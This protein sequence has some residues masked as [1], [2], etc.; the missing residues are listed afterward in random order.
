MLYAL[1]RRRRRRERHRETVQRQSHN[2]CRG[3]RSV[4]PARSRGGV[5]FPDGARRNDAAQVPRAR[6]D[7][8][9]LRRKDILAGCLTGRDDVKSPSSVS[10]TKISRTRMPHARARGVPL[11]RAHAIQPKTA[12]WQQGEPRDGVS[13]MHPRRRTRPRELVPIA[14]KR[15]REPCPAIVEP[16]SHARPSATRR[17]KLFPRL[18]LAMRIAAAEAARRERCRKSHV[19]PMSER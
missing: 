5:A 18:P 17:A 6:R 8:G 1:S 10:W 2:L 12:G 15:D 14:A 11:H 19:C 7:W 13:G 9:G 4:S 16:S 3:G